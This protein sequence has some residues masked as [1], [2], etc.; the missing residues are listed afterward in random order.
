MAPTRHPITAPAISA[1]VVPLVAD[2]IGARESDVRLCFVD[3]SH[4]GV[5]RVRDTVA[6]L[7]LGQGNYSLDGIGIGAARAFV[8]LNP[9]S[10]CISSNAIIPSV[11]AIRRVAGDH[12]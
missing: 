12:T 8:G 9:Y 7:R 2:G 11:V 1:V 3:I 10:S 6:A 5:N 4:P